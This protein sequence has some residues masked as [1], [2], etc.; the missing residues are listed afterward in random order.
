MEEKK[1]RGRPPKLATQ[2]QM[3]KIE[4]M[5]G[6]PLEDYIGSVTDKYKMELFANNLARSVK[7]MEMLTT[8]SSSNGKYQPI[9]SEKL[10][11]DININPQTASSEQ[12][13]RWLL[14]P[15]YYDKDLR[16]LSHYLSYS[17]GQYNRSL[18]YLN[19]IKSYNYVPKFPYTTGEDSKD[20]QYDKDWD[21]Y[22]NVLQKMNIKYN[23]PKIDAQIM[24]DGVACYYL[25]ETSDTISTHNIPIDYCYITAPW[26]FGY[27]FA[28]DLTYF[29]KFA[30]LDDQ[31]P[32]LMEAYKLFTDK[33]KAMYKGEKLAPFQYYQ[34]P[35]SK[36]WVFTFDPIHPD[37]LPP[38]TSSM[39][40][41]LDILSYKELLKNKL[42]LDLYK[43]IALKIPLDKDNKQM[44]ITYKLAE[45]ITQVIQSTLP[46]NMKVYS[47]PFESLPIN[48]DQSNRFDEII[49]IAN[50]N[51]SASTGFNQGLFG[52]NQAKQ[53]LAIQ[54]SAQVDFAYAS[55]HLY[56]QYDNFI[57]YQI[58]IRVKK[59]RFGVRFFGNKL[60][61]KK[62]IELYS[63][64]VRTNNS[65]FFEYF[66]VIGKE[67]FEIVPS[68]KMEQKLGLRELMLPIISG[69]N[70]SDPQDKGGRTKKNDSDL[71]DSG[72][73]TRENGQSQSKSF[74]LQNCI[75]CGHEL[76]VDRV[77]GAFCDEVCKQEYVQNAFESV[78]EK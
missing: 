53:A 75:H 7:Q 12:I 29:D 6:E 22:L 24:F 68:L 31:V 42:A 74:S 55:T 8:Q 40:S 47:S 30:M 3:K 66:S 54:L 17:V 44:A 5:L 38:L 77:D 9:Y 27:T 4:N 70:S 13:E 60:E 63:G 23:I 41:S 19:T 69:F 43:V 33:R 45:E 59:Y 35:P 71:S 56:K 1:K 28:I 34:V 15:Q 26:T 73:R 49:G 2:E 50:D 46:D 16:H 78:N 72:A 11:Q 21:T 25:V 65:A 39:G 62:E 58:A 10:L 51:F 20:K 52:S 18:W 57:N 14:A 64:L 37:K 76:G 36:G 32:E 67:P 61:E 48:T